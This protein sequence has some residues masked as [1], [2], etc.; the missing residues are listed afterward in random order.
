LT[1]KGNVNGGEL[2]LGFESSNA[3]ILFRSLSEMK[4]LLPQKSNCQLSAN[5]DYKYEGLSHRSDPERVNHD[6]SSCL[7]TLKAINGQKDKYNASQLSLDKLNEMEMII[8]ELKNK[9]IDEENNK[10]NDEEK[11]EKENDQSFMSTMSTT[12][13][14]QTDSSFLRS[15]SMNTNTSDGTDE[16]H[17]DEDDEESMISGVRFIE[18]MTPNEGSESVQY[19]D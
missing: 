16:E 6:I 19:Y 9:I 13:N 12:D 11:E 8:K 14:D 4:D 7:N 1:Q 18:D 3:N 2:L 17:E 5:S 10:E 15:R